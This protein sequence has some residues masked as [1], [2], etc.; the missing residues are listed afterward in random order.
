MKH[1]SAICHNFYSEQP[2]QPQLRCHLRPHLVHC[3]IRA[4]GGLLLSS[5]PIM[6]LLAIMII[7][8]VHTC[9]QS[10]ELSRGLRE[11]S[12]CLEIEGIVKHIAQCLHSICESAKKEKAQPYPGTVKLCKLLQTAL[13]VTV[14]THWIP[15]CWISGY[16]SKCQILQ[17]VDI[18]IRDFWTLRQPTIKFLYV[19]EAIPAT[20]RCTA[21]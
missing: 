6:A 18:W 17:I 16:C 15:R 11:I 2:T 3:L 9:G 1:C 21:L 20:R 12:Y 5:A 8:I 13:L 10:I 19:L 7:N 14:H 4:G